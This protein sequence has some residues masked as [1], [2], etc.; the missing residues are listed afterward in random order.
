MQHWR[1]EDIDWGSFDVAKVA[2][3][4]VPLVKAAALVERNGREYAHY[5]CR[6]FIADDA[7]CDVVRQWAEEEVQHGN[8]LGKWAQCVDPGWDFHGARDRFNSGYQPPHNTDSSIRG[9]R[10]GE[11]IARCMVET[12]TSSYYTALA[13]ACREPVLKQLCRR[14]AADEFRHYKLFYAH[15]CRYQAQEHIGTARRA[16]IAAGR[17]GEGEDDELAFA[18]HCA[19]EPMS[20][21]YDRARCSAQYLAGAMLYYR[22]GHIQ[23]GMGMTLKALGLPTQGRLPAVAARLAWWWLDWRRNRL[24]RTPG[25][26]L[27]ATVSA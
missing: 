3:E 13:D 20:M 23:R 7:L 1:I 14:I 5:L 22:F 6:V 27:P 8:A 4:V 24:A 18:Y 17:I 2:P 15:M 16:L 19:N 12:G 26:R 25:V 21:S 9:S 11:L 10:T